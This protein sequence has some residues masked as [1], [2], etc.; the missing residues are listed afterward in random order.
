MT[1]IATA[2]Q[3]AIGTGKAAIATTGTM[4]GTLTGTMTGAMIETVATTTTTEIT[5][6]ATA[7]TNPAAARWSV[8]RCC[9][10]GCPGSLG[11]CLRR[12]GALG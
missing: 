10:L 8:R 2:A 11:A 6:K 1:G 3:G 12:H 7:T 9:C 4:T 5:A